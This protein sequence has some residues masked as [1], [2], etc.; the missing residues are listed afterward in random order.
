[1]DEVCHEVKN[2]ASNIVE[3]LVFMKRS[4]EGPQHAI[5]D[6]KEQCHSLSKM[7]NGDDAWLKTPPDGKL[8]PSSVQLRVRGRIVNLFTSSMS[9]HELACM[10]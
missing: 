3:L 9:C 10:S 4:V 6:A 7:S 5:P 8:Y 1:M 2:T